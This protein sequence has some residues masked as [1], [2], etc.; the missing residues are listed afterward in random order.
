MANHI[1]VP[2][3]ARTTTAANV[4]VGI[5]SGD[6]RVQLDCRTMR[7]SKGYALVPSAR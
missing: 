5:D 6:P 3:H 4:V 1:A 7:A 2:E